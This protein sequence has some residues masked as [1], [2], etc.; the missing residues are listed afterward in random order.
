MNKSSTAAVKGAT[1]N[2]ITLVRTNRFLTDQVILKNEAEEESLRTVLSDNL[3]PPKLLTLVLTQTKAAMKSRIIFSPIDK[4]AFK[5][6][7]IMLLHL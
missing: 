5:V 1:K 4:L 7:H 2:G 3:S 6:V